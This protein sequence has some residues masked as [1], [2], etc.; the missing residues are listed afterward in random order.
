VRRQ[1]VCQE[2]LSD[3]EDPMRENEELGRLF[4]E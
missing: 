2:G 1:R 3:R 4:A